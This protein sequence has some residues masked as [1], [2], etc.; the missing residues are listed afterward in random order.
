MAKPTFN[1]LWRHIQAEAK[2][3][4]PAAVAELRRTQHRYRLGAEFSLLRKET[5]ISQD[6][7]AKRT[8]IDQAEISRIE[9]GASNATE[10]TLARIAQELDAEIA[11]VR[12]GERAAVGAR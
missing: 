1:E 11:L 5:G 8:G 2:A 10:D 7:L 9:R 6:E 4:G 3:E 12:R